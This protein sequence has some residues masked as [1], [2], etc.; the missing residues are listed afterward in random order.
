MLLFFIL[1]LLI[2]ISLLLNVLNSFLFL[3]FHLNYLQRFWAYLFDVLP[4]FLVLL[5]QEFQAV[6][7]GQDVMFLPIFCPFVGV[8]SWDWVVLSSCGLLGL[9]LLFGGL[10]EDFVKGLRGFFWICIVKFNFLNS[11]DWLPNFLLH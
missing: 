10:L 3:L 4:D 1:I 2:D 11:I 6:I 7:E 5:L 8:V 9:G